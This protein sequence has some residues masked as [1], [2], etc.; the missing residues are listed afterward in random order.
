MIMESYRDLVVWGARRYTTSDAERLATCPGA[1]E[2]WTPRTEPAEVP[3]SPRVR[4]G[5]QG[6]RIFYAM[7][8]RVSCGLP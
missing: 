8:N 7:S 4:A 5:P 1:P 2:R 3:H 6:G